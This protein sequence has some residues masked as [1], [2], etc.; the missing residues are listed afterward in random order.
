MVKMKF[1]AAA[2]ASCLAVGLSM[3]TTTTAHAQ[4]ACTPNP[5]TGSCYPLCGGYGCDRTD[6]HNTGCDP[7][8]YN[9]F[10]PANGL[11]LVWSPLCQ[12]NWAQYQ[13]PGGYAQIYVQRAS[14][15]ASSAPFSY[16]GA[17]NM[18]S[19]QLYAP[20]SARACVQLYNPVTVTWSTP[21]C[22]PWSS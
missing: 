11:E 13:N 21:R 19:D 20:G 7:G 3:F 2:A 16:S 1:L 15:A 12:T 14:P 10:P 22:T 9:V 18:W 6:P 8:A 5:V 17:T 4:A